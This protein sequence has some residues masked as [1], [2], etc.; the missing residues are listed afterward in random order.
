MEDKR[1]GAP[2][3]SKAAKDSEEKLDAAREESDL[4]S[5]DEGDDD[6]PAVLRPVDE[7]E[8]IDRFRGR[9]DREDREDKEPEKGE[10]REVER[11]KRFTNAEEL[12]VEGLAS[13]AKN[14]NPRLRALLKGFIQ[15]SLRGGNG[16]YNLD[17]REDEAKVFKGPATSPDC[18]IQLNEKDLIRIANGELNPQIAM[19]SDKVRVEG[20]SEFAVYFF[21]LI[22]GSGGRF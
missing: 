10:R 4:D 11:K 20:K 13:R 17:W 3:G 22:A 16:A 7:D 15:V 6:E 8:E 18:I 21:N 2:G 12:M 9:D 14:A 1:S 19:L 5:D